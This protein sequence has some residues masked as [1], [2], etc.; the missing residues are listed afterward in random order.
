MG[1]S[2]GKDINSVRGVYTNGIMGQRDALNLAQKSGYGVYFNPSNGFLS[3]ILESAFQKF[4]GF[5]G[6]PLTAGFAEQMRMRKTPINIVSH[7]Q[8]TITVANAAMFYGAI[9]KGSNLILDSPAISGPRALL[10]AGMAGG[11]LS[12]NQQWGDGANLWAISLNPMKMASGL[13]DIPMGFSI[14]INGNS[15]ESTYR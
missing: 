5:A 1:V 15:F 7:S 13:I 12:Y 3:D 9:P 11:R 8:G 6:D 2:R 10:A 14:H 4:F